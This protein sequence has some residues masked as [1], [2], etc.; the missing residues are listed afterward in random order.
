MNGD[1]PSFE[2][3]RLF[4]EEV[5]E[6]LLQGEHPLLVNVNLPKTPKGICWS[7]Q[8]VRSYSGNVVAGRDP[9]GRKHYWFSAVP[10]KKPD[11][12]SDRW[13][14]ENNLVSLTP[15]R[16]DLTDEKWLKK[17]SEKSAEQIS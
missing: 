4:V 1:E 7:F 15:L 14:V 11:E 6:M 13:A 12:G 10:R 16:L 2:K 3:Q 8:S 9:M 17:V 5:I